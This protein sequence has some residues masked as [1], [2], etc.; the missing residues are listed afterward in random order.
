MPLPRSHLDS[1]LPIEQLSES[2]VEPWVATS[3]PMRLTQVSE[4]LSV[5]DRSRSIC[6]QVLDNPRVRRGSDAG[7]SP[8]KAR[9]RPYFPKSPK[10]GRLMND[11]T[12]I[13]QHEPGTIEARP[14][15]RRDARLRL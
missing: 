4:F 5:C 12:S 15:R 7:H 10:T 3:E 9:S 11:D 1:G 13:D 8:V 2:V 6:W 14:P